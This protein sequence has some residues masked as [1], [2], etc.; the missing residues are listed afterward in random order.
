MPILAFVLVSFLLTGSASA[1]EAEGITGYSSA[2][3]QTHEDWREFWSGM[4]MLNAA[5]FLYF[6]IA[7]MFLLEAR[8]DS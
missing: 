8:N 2:W 5:V 7:K 1:H 3:F 6:F 4:M